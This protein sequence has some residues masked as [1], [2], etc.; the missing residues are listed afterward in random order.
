MS[1]IIPSCGFVRS[2]QTYEIL[3][4]FPM[5]GNCMDPVILLR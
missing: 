2:W 1:S 4:W 5:G 3:S